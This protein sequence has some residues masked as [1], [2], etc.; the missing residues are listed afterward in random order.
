M[1][2]W[3]V[4]AVRL[5][6]DDTSRVPPYPFAISEAMKS[7]NTNP[8]RIGRSFRRSNGRKGM[9]N[10]SSEIFSRIGNRERKELFHNT[11]TH[12]DGSTQSPMSDR[13]RQKV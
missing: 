6:S 11:G 10:K 5:L 8:P 4:K 9:G 1:G 7:P 13:I 12:V 3:K 2:I